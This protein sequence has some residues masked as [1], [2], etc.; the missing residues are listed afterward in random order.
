MNRKKRFSP[1]LLFFLVILLAFTDQFLY[2]QL[3]KNVTYDQ[4]SARRAFVSQ[5]LPE[6]V[7]QKLFSE[8]AA[9]DQVVRYLTAYQML[10]G[11]MQDGV[12]LAGSVSWELSDKEITQLL[13]A[14]RKAKPEEF[15]WFYHKNT[16]IWSCLKEPFSFPVADVSGRPEASVNYADSWNSARTYGGERTHEG[17][18]L[19]A[20]VNE[21]GLYPILSATDGVVEQMGWLKLGGWRIG[22]RNSSGIY[23]YYAHLAEYA[24][25]K[26][27]DHVTAGTKLGLM[28]DTGY[29]EV[30]GTTGN[31][32]VHLHFGIYI[33]DDDGTEF[34][35]NSYP[36]LRYIEQKT[37][38]VK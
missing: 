28:G 20:S 9:P 6:E 2:A 14:L 18:D 1:I 10:S 38:E 3:R 13:T 29:S 17:T 16:Q 26:V 36:F 11:M 30:P 23:F 19:M 25:L 15:D 31:F 8:D 4:E 24:S 33:N 5:T 35:V 34:A 37:K 12:P 32:P 22:I 27:G 7:W 21:R